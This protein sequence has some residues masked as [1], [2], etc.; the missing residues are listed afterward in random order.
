ALAA[1]E[2]LGQDPAHGLAIAEILEP[3][4]RAHGEHQKLI[5]VHEVQVA[6]ADGAERKVELLHQIASLYEDSAGDANSAFE[7]MARALAVDPSQ[8]E[9]RQN[10]D[11]LARVTGRLL[12][13][14]QVY[15]RLPPAQRDSEVGSQLYS[16]PARVFEQ[17]VPNIDRAID[18]YQRVLAIDPA[19]L[20]AAEALQG[21][22]QGSERYA[23]MSAILQRK[24]SVL[25]DVD[26]Q[27]QALYQAALLE[28][29]VLE[30]PREAIAV[31]QKVLDIDAED[32]RSIDALI[33]L[34]LSLSAWEELLA[35][36]T[37]KVDL[38]LDPTEQKLI[39]SQVGAVFERELS[40]VKR[41]IDTYQRILELD[42]D[43]LTALRRLDV[44]YQTAGNYSE[45]LN[46]L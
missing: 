22:F 26:A 2:R 8:A 24:A 31:Y 45:L 21:L 14:A 6:Q 19:N 12:D 18:L 35:V 27:K 36:Y 16:A 28:E 11:R 7:T 17:D 39:L 20:E 10:I 33:K 32:V 37:K 15:E 23:E 42:P 13:L 38:L 9:T 43:D 44:L 3:L 40:D 30:R 5:G 34:Y 25:E 41:A 4:Y 29:E 46:V 1:L